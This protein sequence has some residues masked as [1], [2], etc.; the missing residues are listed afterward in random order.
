MDCLSPEQT[1]AYVRGGGVDPR[2]VEAHVR[3]CPACAL[4]L[5]LTR[6]TL[7]ETRAK[8]GRP[9]TDRLNLVRK[10]AT[11]AWIPWVAAAAV[12]IAA[13]LLAV[14]SQSPRPPGPVAGK[15]VEPPRPR[16]PVPEPVDPPRPL[17]EPRKAE[18]PAPEPRPAKPRVDP[19][20]EPEP[21]QAPAP[22][23]PV[24][25]PEPKKEPEP[26]M[27]APTLV[28][29]AIVAR[30]TRSMGA[31]AAPV[32]RTFHAG[33]AVTTGRQE[34]LEVAMEGYGRLYFRENSQAEI[35]SSGEITL[36]EGELLARAEPGR[37]WGSLK[38][39]VMQVEPLAPLY[40]VLA[41]KTSA[42]ISI[43]EGRVT[44]GAA[45]SK[46]PSTMFLKAGKAPEVRPLE[47]GF[48]SWLPD[49][50]AAKRF[51]GWFEAED[52]AGLQ[53][54]RIQPTEAASGGK[55]VVQI[56]EQGGIATKAG[57]PFKGRHVVW[58][59]VR[60]YEARPVLIGIH[61]NGQSAGEVKLEWA[62][63]SKPWRW[64]GPLPLNADRLDLA[65]AA[66]SR[67]PLKEGDERRSFP[68]VVDAAVV[69]SDLK[70]SP[71]EKPT[72]DGRGFELGLDEPGGK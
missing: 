12:L 32:G 3:D 47:A 15:P 70:F 44:A 22:P 1:I 52:F 69:S 7:N 35:G 2:G 56:A 58:L 18:P 36:Q 6:E 21:V 37:K 20:R 26:T 41:T 19:P 64:V 39:P 57:L 13:L 60:Q 8:A 66:L 59:R 40:N 10:P 50:L 54:F 46:G 29:K 30:V 4:E 67:W 42:E 71:A 43:L 24:P 61:L 28:E 23:K 27:P 34:Y 65:V 16:P 14:A 62:D 49:K 5:L 33:E 38:L 72:D 45:V 51:S 17:P 31:G 11:A 25:A 9:P 63:G 55:A 53:G 48:A 68:V